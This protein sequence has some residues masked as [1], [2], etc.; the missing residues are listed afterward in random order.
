[1]EPDRHIQSSGFDK[2]QSI[3]DAKGQQFKKDL[4]IK[5]ATKVTTMLAM[6]LGIPALKEQALEALNDLKRMV[7]L[8]SMTLS[9]YVS[10]YFVGILAKVTKFISEKRLG[11]DV[12]EPHAIS[13]LKETME[14]M[15]SNINGHAIHVNKT[16]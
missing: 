14:V 8:M 11:T 3:F 5:N 15:G 2:L 4:A 10:E 7:G 16:C 12:Q 6:N 1:M 9:S 13:A